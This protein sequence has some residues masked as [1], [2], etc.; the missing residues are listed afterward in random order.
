LFAA[1]TRSLPLSMLAGMAAV[2]GLR[3]LTG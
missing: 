1:K 2:A 3:L